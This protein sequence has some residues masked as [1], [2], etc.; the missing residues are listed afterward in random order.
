MAL[1]RAHR[2]GFRRATRGVGASMV[3]GVAA[4]YLAGFGFLW[5]LH[6]NPATATPVTVLR[7]GTYYW[8]RPF[9]RVRLIG[10][11]SLGVLVVVAGGA[12]ALWP[13]RP[14]LFG[15]ARFAT[16]DEMVDAGLLGRTGLIVGKLR[17]RY[18]RLAGQYGVLLAAPPRS[19]KG[20]SV[21]IPNL[22][23][24]EGSVV[25]VDIKGENWDLTAGYRL[26][27]GQEVY[28]LDFFNAHGC[29]H[30]WNPVHYAKVDPAGPVNGL[31][32]LADSLFPDLPRDPFWPATAR[33]MFVGIGLYVFETPGLPATLGEILRQGMVDVENGVGDHWRTILSERAAAGLPLSDTCQQLLGDLASV[34]PDTS[35]SI[36]KT[37]TAAL[38]LWLNPLLDAVTADN[39]FDLE[40]LRKRPMSIYVT[41]TYEDLGR[42]RPVLNLFFQQTLGLLTRELPEQNEVLKVPV[43]MLLDE[44]PALG[45]LPILLSVAGVLPGYNV[46]LLLILQTLAQIRDVYGPSAVDIFLHNLAARIVFAP[47]E[48]ALAEAVSRELGNQTVKTRN[49]SQG[50]FG[51]GR[52]G[53]TTTSQQPRPLMLPQEVKEMGSDTE[54]LFY[55]NLRAVKCKKVR[56]HQDRL[57]SDRV[58]PAPRVPQLVMSSKPSDDGSNQPAPRGAPG[59]AG[60]AGGGEAPRG[61]REHIAAPPRK[62]RRTGSPLR[63]RPPPGTQAPAPQGGIDPEL[64]RAASQLLSQIRGNGTD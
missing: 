3:A 46:R 41:A 32:K 4:L 5:S 62:A 34:S 53:S 49:R 59:A 18:L 9:V 40:A 29:S 60:P 21:V 12:F 45:Y 31:Q 38:S 55:E 28:R 33:S 24:Y 58:Q 19:G 6:L 8:D 26:G 42:L 61:E 15:D 54:L 44:F 13:R 48:Q 22:L 50:E 39:D 16:W 47:K 11:T 27:I 2:R 43:L 1:S 17:G 23:T 52:A 64:D 63:K 7:Y 57:L 10:F 14:S 35:S 56:Y 30:R 36:R 25:T 20:V 37:F 51:S